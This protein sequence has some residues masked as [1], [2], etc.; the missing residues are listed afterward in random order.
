M[1]NK[2]LFAALLTAVSVPICAAPAN[3]AAIRAYAEK[4]LTQCPDMR[5]T[6]EPINQAGPAGFIAFTVT[7]TSSDTTCGRQAVLLFSPATNQVLIGTVF[8]LPADNRSAQERVAL[9]ASQ[10]LKTPLNV[11]VAAF[12][13]PDGLHALSMTKQTPWGP[14]SYHGFMD[15]STQFLIVGSRGNLY[16]D[17]RTTLVE[18]MGLEHAVRRGNPKA[19]TRIIE[20][21]DFQC[22][23]CGRAHKEVEPIIAK[24]LKKID[25]YRL[26]LPLFEHHEWA[27]SAALGAQAIHKVAPAK[28]WD[29]VNFVF[30]NQEEIGKSKSF[31]ETLQNFCEDHDIDWKRVEKIYRSPAERTAMLDQV[32]RAFDNGI[33]AT[34]TYI[35]NGQAIGFGPSGAFTIAAIKKAIGLP[36][37]AAKTPR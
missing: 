10:L 8:G 23:T 17:P 21:S 35:V 1:I 7:Q 25:Y 20:L 13:L 36:T 33:N 22:P 12:P 14:F 29:Y 16:V 27:L 19:R 5:I 31:E 3:L 15:A 37:A 18:S 24:N 26:D 11:S 32:S 2:T 6:V 9:T 34:P 4:A 28:Y 30:A